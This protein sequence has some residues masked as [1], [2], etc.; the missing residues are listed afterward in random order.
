MSILPH[1]EGKTFWCIKPNL[2]QQAR[3]NS[4][5]RKPYEGKLTKGPGKHNWDLVPPA[6]ESTI[7]LR[8]IIDSTIIDNSDEL[9][10]TKAAANRAYRHAQ[11]RYIAQLKID[12]VGAELEYREF[13]NNTETEGKE[14]S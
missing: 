12:L 10:A 13:V 6:V 1:Y 2:W 8:I 7:G 11:S 14:V 3:R 9:F 4:A 5:P